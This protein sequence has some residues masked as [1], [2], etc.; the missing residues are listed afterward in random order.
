MADAAVE[1]RGGTLQAG[2][3]RDRW[4]AGSLIIAAMAVLTALY[5]TQTGAGA[6]GDSVHY[7]MGA[8]N[9]LEGNGYSRTTGDGTTR[10][11]TH[12]PPLFS[13]MIAAVGMF[14]LE[15]SSA[16]RWLNAV[17]FGANLW[18]TSYLVFRGNRKVF[19]A[20]L[21]PVA[22]AI[23]A[24]LVGLHAW[25]MSEPVY[26]F[27]SLVALAGLHHYLEAGDLRSLLVAAVAVALATLTRY[28]GISL[29]LTGGL[30]ILIFGDAESRQR[31]SHAVLFGLISSALIGLWFVRNIAISGV[32]ANREISFHPIR[33]ELV[34]RYIAVAVEWVFA[35][36]IIPWRF[37]VLAAAAIGLAAPVVLMIRDVRTKG[38]QRLIGKLEWLLI[39]YLPSYVLALAVNSFWLDASAKPGDVERY[40]APVSVAMIMLT[41]VSYW[42]WWAASAPRS[43]FRVAI[44][45]VGLF[46]IGLHVLETT[47]LF[48]RDGLDRG[49]V[50]LAE[51]NPELASALSE[52]R[53]DRVLISNN[54]ELVYVISGRPA[55]AMPIAFDVS[56]QVARQDF[57]QQV[58]ATV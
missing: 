37:R 44:P 16:A 52:L 14:G 51:N 3:S 24:P 20:L 50:T 15:V 9:I 49:Y 35:R 41:I 42:K 38:S 2:S 31:L 32:A 29:L 45:I 10:P 57:D 34:D 4:L 46:L 7:L 23:A 28:V 33:R 47:P 26:I 55:F 58:S 36:A 11:I 12:F 27:F 43:P 5:I 25:I 19:P 6:S 22:L 40:L 8:E 39:L 18:L 54:P 30:A 48:A 53:A 13:V 17:L 56:T 21:T 1:V